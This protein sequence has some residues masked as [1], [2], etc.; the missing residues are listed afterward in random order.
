MRAP[1]AMLGR[2]GHSGGLSYSH[3]RGRGAEQLAITGCEA[4]QARRCP[5]GGVVR[6]ARL[7]PD[8]GTIV[9]RPQPKEHPCLDRQSVI[10]SQVSAAS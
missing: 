9:R 3:H 2:T 5:E 8:Q 1:Q 4:P 6:L 7:P 10:A